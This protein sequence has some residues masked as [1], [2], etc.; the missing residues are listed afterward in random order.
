MQLRAGIYPSRHPEQTDGWRILCDCQPD[1]IPTSIGLIE[2]APT[3]EAE[4]LARGRVYARDEDVV[5]TLARDD[6]GMYAHW[7][8]ISTHIAPEEVMTVLREAAAAAVESDAAL[9]RAV[10][11]ARNA[12]HSWDAIGRAVNMSR[13]AAHARWSKASR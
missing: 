13:Q 12:G 2:R 9:D 5:T 6:V 7:Q 3:P 1:E 4:D 11:G 8:W 10:I